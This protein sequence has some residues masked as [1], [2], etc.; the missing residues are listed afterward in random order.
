MP[1]RTRESAL[2]VLWAGVVTGEVSPRL[3][4]AALREL[5]RLE[6]FLADDEVKATVMRGLLA[7]GVPW[8]VG[9]DAPVAAGVPGEV[10]GAGR[11]G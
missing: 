7:L 9:D 6:P 1:V 11:L 5:G 2:G 8:G 10:R 3:A 4:T